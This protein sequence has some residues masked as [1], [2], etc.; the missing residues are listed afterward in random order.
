MLFNIFKNKSHKRI[1]LGLFLFFL[2]LFSL[3]LSVGIG[4]SV[5]AQQQT[6][7]QT[8]AQTGSQVTK[9]TTDVTPGMGSNSSVGDGIAKIL[10]WITEGFIKLIG[11]IFILFLDILLGV[12]KFNTFLGARAVTVGWVVIRD[13]ANIFLVIAM[14]VVALGTLFNISAYEYKKTLPKL[15][16]AA[17]LVNFSKMIV[18][19]AIDV[20]Q[21]IMMT[22]V[23]AFSATASGGVLNALGVKSMLDLRDA[24]ESTGNNNGIDYW[25]IFG[26]V[27]LALVMLVI[28]SVVILSLIVVLAFRIIMLWVLIIFAP[29]AFVASVLPKSPLQKVSFFGQY[30]DQLSRYIIIGPVLAFFLWLSFYLMQY[31]SSANRQHIIDL[32]MQKNN[33][34]LNYQQYLANKIS[35]PQYMFDYM[36]A[37]ALLLG[38]LVVTQKIGVMGGAMGSNFVNKAQNKIKN[39]LNGWSRNRALNAGR[40]LDRTSIKAQAA[41]GKTKV[42]KFFGL[43]KPIS[44]RPSLRKAAKDAHQQRVDNATIKRY[45]VVGA[46]EDKL[47]RGTFGWK[48]DKTNH[49]QLERDRYVAQ[50]DKEIEESTSSNSPKALAHEFAQTS[51]VERKEAYLYNLTRKHGLNN[52]IDGPVTSQSVKKLVAEHFGDEE[53]GK[54]I[55]AN[56]ETIGINGKYAQL[57][58]TTKINAETGK[59]EWTYDGFEDKDGKQAKA[60]AR[61]QASKSGVSMITSLDKDAMVVDNGELTRP[62]KEMFKAVAVQLAKNYDRIDKTLQDHFSQHVGA[63]KKFADETQDPE[64]KRAMYQAIG[65]MINPNGKG[66]E[67][68][69]NGQ[70][71]KSTEADEIIKQYQ[72]G[73][74]AATL[75]DSDNELKQQQQKFKDNETK[76]NDYERAAEEAK[77]AQEYMASKGM[78]SEDFNYK[79]QLNKEQINR[80][81]A[82]ELRKENK[83]IEESLNTQ[84]RPAVAEKSVEELNEY[85]FKDNQAVIQVSNQL[86]DTINQA[87]KD[88]KSPNVDITQLN[89]GIDQAVKK[90]NEELKNNLKPGY[91]AP[92]LGFASGQSLGKISDPMAHKSVLKKLGEIAK[93]IGEKAQ[94]NNT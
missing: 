87:L 28:A 48:G 39:S 7:D 33:A 2:L 23:N 51:S 3:V 15:M 94:T 30:W 25:S 62:A 72:T 79:Q 86:V 77:Q 17:I 70:M 44:L 31:Q 50:I 59:R 76:I 13:L 52:L 67:L 83:K 29:I 61:A 65:R 11:V 53:E 12:V 18:G 89:H 36:V 56:L 81:K 47:N 75:S 84:Y 14:L 8:D 82:D 10:I 41:L 32:Y 9:Q 49:Q 91:H 43:N 55:M 78:G 92:D 21:V 34:N 22:F 54:R 1:V 16:V 6:A 27:A 74:T 46:M 40:R 69:R 63:F 57:M 19:I 24:I 73:E 93:K 42:G 20:G 85:A 26:A 58:G 64:D 80:Q 35:S 38:S 45:G 88:I 68:F 66:E 4:H 5:F 37:I 90:L 71:V 60:A